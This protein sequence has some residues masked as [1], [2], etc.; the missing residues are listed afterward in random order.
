LQTKSDASAAVARPAF[1]F[2]L[3]AFLECMERRGDRMSAIAVSIVRQAEPS[4]HMHY[5]A[6]L[7]G[8]Q[9][10]SAA[11][12]LNDAPESSYVRPVRQ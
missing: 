10:R 5:W 2:D 6:V 9:L 1:P 3:K 12:S 7:L 11:I 4:Q 8:Y